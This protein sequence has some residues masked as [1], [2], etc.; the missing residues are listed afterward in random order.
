MN[1]IKKSC[2]SFRKINKCHNLIL[3]WHPGLSSFTFSTSWSSGRRKQKSVND[4]KHQ[5]K[6][7]IWFQMVISV[8][9]SLKNLMIMILKSNFQLHVL[10]LGLSIWWLNE[11]LAWPFSMP[12]CYF[13]FSW[14]LPFF[15]CWYW[16]CC[17]SICQSWG[18][19]WGWHFRP[20]SRGLGCDQP[21][22]PQ[23]SLVG[24]E[25]VS[26]PP[27]Y[28]PVLPVPSDLWLNWDIIMLE[29]WLSNVIL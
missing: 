4:E 21:M 6:N 2:G 9:K 29:V 28:L 15:Q 8:E 13:S 3:V 25:G 18:G 11:F 16:C 20:Q 26:H 5:V 17:Q 23:M 14:N 12:V 27:F 19:V 1:E 22:N 24:W 10:S 7:I